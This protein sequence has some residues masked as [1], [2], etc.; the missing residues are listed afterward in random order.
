MTERNRNAWDG[1]GGGGGAVYGLGFVG[2]LIYYIQQADGFWVGVLGVLKA[3][4]WPA[5]VVYD[6]LKFL[7]S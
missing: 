7:G 4:V 3:F 1:R 5:F 2:A 6:L